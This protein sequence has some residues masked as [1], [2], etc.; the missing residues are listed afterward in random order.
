MFRI[1]LE[2]E[3][4]EMLEGLDRGNVVAATYLDPQKAFDNVDHTILLQKLCK[5]DLH[6]N[7]HE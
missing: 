7:V 3:R 1:A 4:L 2:P 5:Y 6:G